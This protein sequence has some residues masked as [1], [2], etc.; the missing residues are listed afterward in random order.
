[1]AVWLVT[2]RLS[3]P[4]FELPAT[5][6][7][8]FLLEVLDA[9][10]LGVADEA[11]LASIAPRYAWM[12]EPIRPS[13][14]RAAKKAVVAPIVAP[15]T[16]AVA[17]APAAPSTATVTTT[18]TEASS[19]H[20]E[21]ESSHH[22][23]DSS[24]SLDVHRAPSTEERARAKELVDLIDGVPPELR[25]DGPD[26]RFIMQ[27][28][29]SKQNPSGVWQTRQY[30][31]FDDVLVWTKPNLI[32]KRSVFKG[33]IGIVGGELRQTPVGETL[34]TR[35][36]FTVRGG[37]GAIAGI[38]DKGK[39]YALKAA[40]PGEKMTWVN[41]VR[42]LVAP[43]LRHALPATEHQQ[44]QPPP[45]P[46]TSQPPPPTAT[47]PVQPAEQQSSLAEVPP[48]DE[49]LSSSMR[50]SSSRR[51]VRPKSALIREAVDVDEG[52]FASA[53]AV[54]KPPLVTGPSLAS[55]DGTRPPPLFIGG[56]MGVNSIV[57]TDSDPSNSNS[58]LPSKREEELPSPSAKPPPPAGPPPKHVIEATAK[59]QAVAAAAATRTATP[60][61]KRRRHKHKSH[62][63]DEPAAPSTPTNPA[64]LEPATSSRRKK[65]RSS[66]REQSTP[67]PATASGVA[68]PVVA[69]A[70][71]P[72]PGPAP[73]KPSPPPTVRPLESEHDAGPPPPPS[74]STFKIALRKSGTRADVSDL[75]APPQLA[76][77]AHTLDA[78]GNQEE[79][80]EEDEDEEDEEDVKEE[81]EHDDDDDGD[82]VV[83]EEVFESED[84]D[85]DDV[86]AAGNAQAQGSA[87]AVWSA[88]SEGGEKHLSLDTAQIERMLSPPP[89]APMAIEATTVDEWQAKMQA[90]VA[91]KRAARVATAAPPA[92]TAPA[93][94][95]V[96]SAAP[97]VPPA[98]PSPPAEPPAP[99][100][101]T[102]EATVLFLEG[103]WSAAR[104]AASEA[105]RAGTAVAESA[106][107]HTAA[108]LMAAAVRLEVA[109]A[110][111]KSQALKSKAARK[112]AR[113]V[114]LARS[115]L[116]PLS[117]A[118]AGVCDAKLGNRTDDVESESER[119]CFETFEP[120][121]VDEA[122][123]QCG[124]CASVFSATSTDDRLAPSS[125]CVVCGTGVLAIVEAEDDDESE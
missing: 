12:G 114:R 33:A 30:L 4:F 22:S 90:Q 43:P 25:L 125:N 78:D 118:A 95:P 106:Q 14:T 96:A 37:M 34:D 121:E 6:S 79:K 47:P 29:L 64:S 10:T 42:P 75:V 19:D 88:L 16:P 40:T 59:Q 117:S 56:L 39:V 119:W 124:R 112:A 36:C 15:S 92:V 123:L 27:G 103:E 24:R 67:A 3:N 102:D 81:D 26:H 113:L 46:Q 49:P 116:A 2:E 107:L 51:L 76:A 52:T 61:D 68:T 87:Q 21:H 105:M 23:E 60:Q 86:D 13:A 89:V 122:C 69:P 71:V 72:P 66:K 55:I 17:A 115:L 44:Q 57:D 109:A 101:R 74:D 31:L 18:T 70:V 54:S 97:P 32:G 82:E 94:E 53:V 63:K 91:A 80:D 73:P 20:S 111:G 100:P 83:S 35:L 7:D 104:D 9:D 50:G 62:S 45:P 85:D 77:G 58:P 11:V 65:S 93:V 120:I 108:R 98:P 99:P 38:V 1:M 41:A 5:L 84:E 28:K 48:P 8:Q 110:A